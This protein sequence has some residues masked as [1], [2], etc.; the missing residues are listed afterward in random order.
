MKKFIA[1][2]CVGAIALAGVNGFDAQAKKKKNTKKPAKI[3]KVAPAPKAEQTQPECQGKEGCDKM[4]SGCQKINKVEGRQLKKADSKGLMKVDSK[5]G[6][7]L[8]CKDKAGECKEMKGECGKG[9]CGKGECKE[10]EHKCAH[11]SPCCKEG[12]CK[13]NGECGKEKCK[14]PNGNCCK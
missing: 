14:D 4:K 9:E 3:E 11:Q 7:K 10:G 2:L 6:N 12:A 13:K 5:G 8:E 1:L